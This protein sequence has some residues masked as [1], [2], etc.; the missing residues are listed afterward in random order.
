MNQYPSSK[1]KIFVDVNVF[2]LRKRGLYKIYTRDRI[3]SDTKK[4]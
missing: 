2:A 3:L 4:R 1:W